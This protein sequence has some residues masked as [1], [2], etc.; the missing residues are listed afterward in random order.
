M[1]EIKIVTD[2]IITTLLA[3]WIIFLIY[4]IANNISLINNTTYQIISTFFLC[5][6]IC[7]ITNFLIKE[8]N[9]LK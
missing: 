5:L 1:T 6:N 7:L 2:T 3:V 4:L 8:Y 9:K